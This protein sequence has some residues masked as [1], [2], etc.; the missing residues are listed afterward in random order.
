[1]AHQV[2]SPE[3]ETEHLLL[4]LL[5]ADMVLAR[6]FLGSPWAADEIWQEIEGS[7]PVRAIAPGAEDLPLSTTAKRVLL[8][9]AEEADQL[10][11][12]KIRTEHL[13]LGL[14]R[15]EK[16]LAAV[17][18]QGHGL[19]LVSTREEL[20]R[21]PHDDSATEK[22]VREPS[23]LPQ[24]VVELQ[25]RIR[26]IVSRLEEAIADHD[27]VKAR[28]CSNEE[29]IERDKLRLLCQEHGLSGWMFD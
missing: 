2:G 19:G 4:G 8:L 29:R 10:S 11:S 26:S 6:R 24:S 12:K 23:P 9:T 25:T 22:F 20:S 16:C 1:M 7:K 28:S 13:L 27:F 3:I 15:D 17:L 5:R 14:L 18:L 21:S